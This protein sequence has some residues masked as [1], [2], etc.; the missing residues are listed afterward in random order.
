MYTRG[1]LNST[2]CRFSGGLSL[3]RSQQ[4]S[5]EPAGGAIWFFSVPFNGKITEVL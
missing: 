1:T 5:G 4:S 3:Q 2:A